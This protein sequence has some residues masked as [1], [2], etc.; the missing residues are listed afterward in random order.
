MILR[1][2][3]MESSGDKFPNALKPWAPSLAASEVGHGSKTCEKGG[4]H[5]FH[6]QRAKNAFAHM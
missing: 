5:G 1:T 6:R 4:S 2:H 3:S